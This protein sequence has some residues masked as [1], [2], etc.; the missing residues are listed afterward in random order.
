MPPLEETLMIL[1]PELIIMGTATCAASIGITR[2]RSTLRRHSLP[3]GY[4]GPGK[5]AAGVVHQHAQ[6]PEVG[7]LRHELLDRLCVSSVGVHQDRPETTIV[8]LG[9]EL[10]GGRSVVSVGDDDAQS[11]LR[12]PLRDESAQTS[13]ATGDHCKIDVHG[14]VLTAATDKGSSQPS[15]L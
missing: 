14:A 11:P 15:P 12:K 4:C 5:A 3:S 7:R 8:E 2:F 1:P 6:L 9:D 10:G 13:R